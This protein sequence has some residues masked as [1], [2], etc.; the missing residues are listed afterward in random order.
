MVLLTSAGKRNTF[1]LPIAGIRGLVKQERNKYH[2]VG[3]GSS[4]DCR[5]WLTHIN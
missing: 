5:E 4:R 1:C 2:V 3:G